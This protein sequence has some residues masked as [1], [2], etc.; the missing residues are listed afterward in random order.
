MDLNA[1]TQAHSEW[2]IKLRMAIAKKET[3]DAATIAKDNC[4]ALGKWLHGDAK[5]HFA[6][7]KAYGDCL[8]RHA[9][10]HREAGAVAHA[11]NSGDY[12]KASTMLDGGTP[13]AAASNAVAGAI[14][15]LKKEV[16][17]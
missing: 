1:A 5:Q 8:T 14:L 7:Y 15:A 16:A 13:Y 17:L 4:C 2:K 12:A 9:T 3:L 6:N 10:F 11:I